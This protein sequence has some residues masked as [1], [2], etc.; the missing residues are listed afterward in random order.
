MSEKTITEQKKNFTSMKEKFERDIAEKKKNAKK[1]K[2]LRK[3]KL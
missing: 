1:R 2:K 3:G